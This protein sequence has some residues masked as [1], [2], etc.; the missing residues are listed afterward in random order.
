MER[1]K[2]LQILNNIKEEAKTA[3]PGILSQGKSMDNYIGHTVVNLSDMT[4]TTEQTKALEKGLTVC[5]T[6]GPPNKSQ[7]WTDFKEFHRRLCLKYHFHKVNG[8]FDHLTSEEP[9]LVGF[10]ASNLEHCENPYKDLHSQFRN[11]SNWK[12]PNTHQ[13]LDV[14]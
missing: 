8:H 4:L 6:P 13:S 14:F 10:L 9:E 7:I 12:P 2:Y 11:K 1:I 3:P 5:P